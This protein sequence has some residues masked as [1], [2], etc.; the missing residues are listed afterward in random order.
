MKMQPNTDYFFKILIE[1][2]QQ[3]WVYWS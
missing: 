2:V 1:A 3:R